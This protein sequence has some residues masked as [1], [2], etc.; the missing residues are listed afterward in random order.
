MNQR[1]MWLYNNSPF[2]DS[3]DWYGFIYEI[4]NNATGKKYIGRKY[5][6]TAKTKQVKGKKKR[7]RVESDW[8]DYWGSNKTLQADIE[9]LGKENFTRKIL[10][11]CTTRGNTN[12]WEAK[13]QFDNNV[14]IDDNYYNDWI[15]IKTHRKHIKL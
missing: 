12:Y 10:M 9:E 6:S 5:F 7:I 3:G 1:K 15:M 13:F 4:T 14:L 2:E 8:R 11:L